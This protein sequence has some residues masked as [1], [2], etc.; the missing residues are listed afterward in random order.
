MPVIV[1]ILNIG[2]L[3]SGLIAREVNV[4]ITRWQ[5]IGSPP[6][7]G[8]WDFTCADCKES[9]W[10]EIGG[11]PAEDINRPNIDIVDGTHV[12]IVCDLERE[13]LPFHD[14]HATFIKAIHSLQH[15]SRDGARHVLEECY[16][17]LDIGGR[18]Y[19]MVGD[20]DFLLERLREDGLHESWMN[21]IFHGP[22]IDE[23]LGMHKW[24]YNFDTLKAEL[25]L[26]GFS[27]VKHLGYYNRWEFKAE[28]FKRT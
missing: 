9:R 1:L 14:R 12:D 28:A 6:E 11:G 2:V 10:I 23:P 25:E 5:G 4:D 26:A 16:R 27:D 17:I 24:G 19:V 8:G 15:L 3:R 18:L 7:R 21:C 22:K 13:N 20:F